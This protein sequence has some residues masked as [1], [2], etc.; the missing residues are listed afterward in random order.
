M[1]SST[2]TD[3]NKKNFQSLSA[4]TAVYIQKFSSYFVTFVGQAGIIKVT[5]ALVA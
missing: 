2:P 5:T 4:K 3:S 1:R